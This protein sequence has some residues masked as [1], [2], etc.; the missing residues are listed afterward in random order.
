[1]YIKTR[2][3]ITI[4]VAH[5]FFLSDCSGKLTKSYP[6]SNDIIVMHETVLG[7]PQLLLLI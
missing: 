1:M 5:I 6:A 4:R 2:I 7:C 3:L